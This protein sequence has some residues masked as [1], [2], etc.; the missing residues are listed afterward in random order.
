MY[1]YLCVVESVVSY[2]CVFDWA[3]KSSLALAKKK[4]G[5]QWVRRGWKSQVKVVAATK[6]IEARNQLNAID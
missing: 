5:E 2:A 4:L 1:L 6:S 3:C